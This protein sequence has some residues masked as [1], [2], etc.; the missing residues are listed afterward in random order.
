MKHSTGRI[1]GFLI[2]ITWTSF[3]ILYII[4]VDIGLYYRNSDTVPP[5][6]LQELYANE[7]MRWE[8]FITVQQTVWICMV[9]GALIWIGW[10]S[11]HPIT[12]KSLKSFNPDRRDIVHKFNKENFL[13]SIKAPANYRVNKKTLKKE[14]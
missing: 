13:K 5:Q 11:I 6:W 1:L 9:G 7:Y 8:Y 10:Q 4:V 3:L 2:F 12:T 14:N